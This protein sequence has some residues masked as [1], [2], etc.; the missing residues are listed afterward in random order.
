MD[1]IGFIALR[2]INFDGTE[3]ACHTNQIWIDYVEDYDRL[4]NNIR[5][6]EAVSFCSLGYGDNADKYIKTSCRKA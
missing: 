6:G 5:T 3:A 1:T 2:D 4:V